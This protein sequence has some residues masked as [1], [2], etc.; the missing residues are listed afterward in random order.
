MGQIMIIDMAGLERKRRACRVG[1]VEAVTLAMRTPMDMHRSMQLGRTA[2]V[3]D[4]H[5]VYKAGATLLYNLYGYVLAGGADVF[6]PDMVGACN[7]LASELAAKSLEAQTRT[8][9]EKAARHAASRPEV[10]EEI[11][12]ALIK[13][14]RVADN[15]AVELA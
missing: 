8:V 4:A 10:V 6:G 5:K 15:F 12:S 7:E 13:V 3:Q 11:Q 1:V 14:R 9:L 2:E